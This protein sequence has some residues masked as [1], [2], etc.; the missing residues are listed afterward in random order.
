MF[1]KVDFYLL[2]SCRQNHKSFFNAKI[3]MAGKLRLDSCQHER[4][5]IYQLKKGGFYRQAKV[6]CLAGKNGGKSSVFSKSLQSKH[7]TVTDRRHSATVSPLS[8][9][10]HP[11]YHCVLSASVCLLIAWIVLLQSN[12]NV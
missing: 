6:F 12:F 4:C 8:Y 3:S 9:P 2:S 5:C 11:T 10:L 7:I 1:L